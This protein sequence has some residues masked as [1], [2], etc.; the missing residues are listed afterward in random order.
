M[1][2]ETSSDV[3]IDDSVMDIDGIVVGTTSGVEGGSVDAI[4][5]DSIPTD[6]GVTTDVE[7]S[8][9]IGRDDSKLRLTLSSSSSSVSDDSVGAGRR[10]V[11]GVRIS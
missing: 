2:D 10:S 5:G 6:A 11:L 8:V 7:P 3:E 1:N 9:D 4:E